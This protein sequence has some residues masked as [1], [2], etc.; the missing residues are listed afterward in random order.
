MSINK[1]DRFSRSLFA[2]DILK[3][4]RFAIISGEL[5]SKYRL[6]EAKLAQEFGVSRGP[7][8]SAIHTLEQQGL[9]RSLP[10]GGAEVVGFPL[11]SAIDWL[12]VRQQLE[13]LAA[14]LMMEN[15]ELSINNLKAIVD[16][17]FKPN[18][19]SDE[20]TRLDFEFHLEFVKLSGNLAL[21]QQWI[22]LSPVIADIFSYT[23]VIYNNKD[24]FPYDHQIIYNALESKNLDELIKKMNFHISFTIKLVKDN[25][26]NL[27]K[28]S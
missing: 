26:K 21:V 10:S 1:I 8:R 16:A 11:K 17:M 3:N 22:N 5:P 4:L 7:V 18:I 15:K 6:V 9:V 23:Q 27:P 25:F 12:V 28:K 14:R 19:D 13:V 24:Q 20:L 2:K